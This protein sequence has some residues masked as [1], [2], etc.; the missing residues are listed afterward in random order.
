MPPSQGGPTAVISQWPSC[1]YGLYQ[2]VGKGSFGKVYQTMDIY[3]GG[4]VA[5]KILYYHPQNMKAIKEMAVKEVR[6]L[7]RM[8][9]L[10]IINFKD[11]FEVFNDSNTT[12]PTGVAIVTEFCSRGSLCNFLQLRKGRRIP[13]FDRIN[14]YIQLISALAY[15]HGNKIVHRDIKPANILVDQNYNLK[16]ADLGLA[17]DFPPQQGGMHTNVMSDI[18]KTVCGTEYFMAPE[19]YKGRYTNMSDIFSM[20]LVMLVICELPV[21]SIPIINI[22]SYMATNM[23]NPVIP[24]DSMINILAIH[25]HD[26]E[27]NIFLKMLQPI[28]KDRVS[29][30]RVLLLLQKEREQECKTLIA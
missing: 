26:F 18:M 17:R 11:A 1:C 16:L 30:C 15:M 19:V 25:S 22:G 14:W 13:Y 23:L 27:K 21:N 10:N 7:K 20:G 24:V 9:H 12:T 5:V 4:V 2:D 6:I 3:T 29:A 28:Y 8:N